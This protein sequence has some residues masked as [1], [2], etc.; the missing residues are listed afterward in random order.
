VCS[1]LIASEHLSCRLSGFNSIVVGLETQVR[2]IG[3]DRPH[4][5]SLF[6][7]VNHARLQNAETA[8]AENC[9]ELSGGLPKRG[10][11]DSNETCWQIVMGKRTRLAGVLMYGPEQMTRDRNH[12]VVQLGGRRS[13]R[14]R[15]ARSL[16]K[17]K[18]ARASDC[19]MHMPSQ[20]LLPDSLAERHRNELRQQTVLCEG[21]TES[22]RPDFQPAR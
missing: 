5:T 12:I 20:N 6:Y 3:P 14:N 19:K 8:K 7:D 21:E 15:V 1:R 9:F 4:P 11:M 10:L 13:R 16:M 17:K 2:I 22:T 18:C